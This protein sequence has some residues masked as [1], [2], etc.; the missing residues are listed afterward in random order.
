MARFVSSHRDEGTIPAFRGAQSSRFIKWML[1][2]TQHAARRRCRRESLAV[3]AVITCPGLDRVARR[4]ANCRRPADRV[5]PTAQRLD[6]GRSCPWVSGDGARAGRDQPGVH[7]HRR[8]LASHRRY[9]PG[10]LHHQHADPVGRRRDLVDRLWR[11]RRLAGH[12]VPLSRTPGVRVGAAV[13]AGGARLCAR[14]CLHRRP[15][16]RRAGAD[17]AARLV[18]M[19]AAGLLV[20]AHPLGRGRRRDDDAGALSLCLHGRTRCLPGAVGLRPRGQPHPRPRSGAGV[21]V[22]GLAPGPTGDRRRDDAGPDGG[23]RRLRHGRAFRRA[24]L[25]HR[26]LPD[27]VRHGRAGGRRP[28][29][30]RVAAVRRRADPA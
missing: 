10:R 22:G 5:D 4:S 9:G 17:G 30:R 25:H 3:E 21:L 27:L 23:H 6:R 2:R 15:G 26:H 29:C 19:G 13:A 7:G 14:L 18:R 16:I 20:P 11:R 1:S 8:R 28:A 12:H 24:D